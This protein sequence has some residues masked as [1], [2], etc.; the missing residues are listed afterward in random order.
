MH[1]SNTWR[2]PPRSASDL[3]GA[4]SSLLQNPQLA[5]QMGRAGRLRVE[6]VFTRQQMLARLEALYEEVV[7]VDAGR[8]SRD[9]RRSRPQT[10]DS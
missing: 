1:C 8:D 10:T 6:D 5:L 2:M 3:G 7:T 4:L 9:S